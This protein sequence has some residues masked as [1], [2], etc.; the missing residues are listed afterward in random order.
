MERML[1]VFV[2]GDDQERLAEKANVIERYDA[3]VLAEAPPA[4]AKRIARQYLTEDI[5]DQ[6]QLPV[7]TP[8]GAPDLPRGK[9]HYLVQ[10]IGPI[11][12]SWLRGVRRAGGEPR[13]LWSGF[14]YVVRT[15]EKGIAKIRL[16][17][18]STRK[19]CSVTARTAA[20]AIPRP[21]RG[22]PSQ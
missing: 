17:S 5:T 6:Y 1:K 8:R 16:S 14:T 2:E 10:F 9:H 15:D 18:E 12:E 3:F 19:A 21:H 11:K 22:R 4:A 20:V 13:Q 7:A